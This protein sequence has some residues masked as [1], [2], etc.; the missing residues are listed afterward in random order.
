MGAFSEIQQMTLVEMVLSTEVT[1]LAHRLWL[2]SS[3]QPGR[4]PCQPSCSYLANLLECCDSPT[5]SKRMVQ[6]SGNIPHQK[7]TQPPSLSRLMPMVRLPNVPMTWRFR[8]LLPRLAGSETEIKQ[9]SASF[10]PAASSR[11]GARR[12]M[13][14]C[15]L[16]VAPAQDG[17]LPARL[18]TRATLVFGMRVLLLY[19]QYVSLLK[20]STHPNRR[21]ATE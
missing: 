16:V 12:K 2:E 10:H 8:K 11:V 5:S 6:I 3:S 7:L 9:Q 15:L 21:T 19:V 20:P 14:S 17:V 4:V 18:Q 1:R 13:E